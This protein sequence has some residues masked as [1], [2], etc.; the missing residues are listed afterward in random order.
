MVARSRRAVAAGPIRL[1]LGAGP[2]PL[3]GWTNVD[4]VGRSG[5]D[6]ALDVRRP[7]PFPTASVAA[8]FS[9]HMLEH[10]TYDDAAPL[11]A[12]C[13]RV[14]RPRGVIRIV[15][16]DFGRYARA[17]VADDHG[18]LDSARG[19]STTPLMALAEVLYGYGHRSI[20]DTETLVGALRQA[21]LEAVESEFGVSELDPCPDNPARRMESLYVEG[22]EGG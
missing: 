10:L 14:L 18:F 9:E 11:L 6:L 2:T 20:W 5:A 15:V 19:R 21:G 4:L 22:V 3:A 12:E 17:Y 7:L 8:I 16:P 1:H 13:A